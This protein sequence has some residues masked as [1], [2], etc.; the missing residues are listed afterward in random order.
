MQN[1]RGITR[2]QTIKAGLAGAASLSLADILRLRAQSAEAGQTPRDTAVI[3][4][5]QEGGASQFETYDPK[6]SAPVEFRGEFDAIRTSVPGVLFSEAMPRQAALMHRLTV[7]RSLHHPS[8]QHS[9]SVHLLKTGFYCRAESNDNEMPS[10]G[11]YVARIRGANERGMPPYALLYHAE[12]YDGGHFLGRGYNPFLVRTS[13][14]NRT[15][16]IP[17]SIS[18]LDGM[19]NEQ[20]QDRQRLLT[21]F[22]DTRRALDTQGVADSIDHFRRQAFEMVSSPLARRAFNLDAEPTAVR[23]RYGLTPIGQRM[24]LARRLV[25]H[26]VTFVTVGTFGWDHHSD[27]WSDLRRNGPMFDQGVAA[28]V[29]DLQQRGLSERVLVVIMG[30]FGREPRVTSLPN[31]TPGREHWGNSMS[32]LLAG[33]GLRGGQVV[34]ATDSRGG[35]PI[36]SPYRTECVLAHAYRHLGIDPAQTFPDF[37]GRPRN[38]LDVR[39]VIRELA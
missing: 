17:S 15:M 39:G 10:V 29:E 16:Q 11:S 24:L 37:S 21:Q 19:T 4:I 2:R 28:L 30:E 34:G 20:W 25:E 22:D 8:T 23:E 14:D 12:R 31:L 5:L 36:E 27:L 6:P 1:S 13:N 32:A 3:Y 38:L 35:F 9:S 26:G 18:L 7:L 33:G